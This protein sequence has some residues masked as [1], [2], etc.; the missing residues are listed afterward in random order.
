MEERNDSLMLSE[1]AILNCILLISDDRQVRGIDFARLTFELRSFDLP[2]PVIA[3][4]KEIA[5]KFF[6]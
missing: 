4:S 3:T 5:R 2:A 1:A 6:K